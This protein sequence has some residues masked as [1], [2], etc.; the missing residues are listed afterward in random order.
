MRELGD[1]LDKDE[2]ARILRDKIIP[3]YG[4]DA[5]Q[6]HERPKA[7]ILGGQPGA[8]KGGL[9]V[10]AS[11]DLGGDAVSIDPD[12]LRTHHPKLED[13]RRENPYSWSSRTHPDASAWADELLEV[14]S[15]ERKN[16][17]F[18]ST[19]SNGE[20]AADTLIKGLKEKG[21]D[22]EIRVVAAHKMESEIGVD[23]RFAQ[24]LDERG[25]G[26]NVPKEAR[27]AIYD[28][29]PASLDVV[30]SRTDVA[31]RIFSR[32]GDELYNSQRD[33]EP[34]GRVLTEA[35]NSRLQEPAVTQ[36]LRE[37]SARLAEWNRVLPEHAKN[38]PGMDRAT[39]GRLLAEHARAHGMDESAFRAQ[40]SAIVDELVR[41]GAPPSR[42]P[43]PDLEFGGLRSSAGAAGLAGIG[44]AASAYDA[45]ET[46]ERV[47]ALLQQQ[48]LPAAQS[49]LTHFAARG[50]GGWAG[51]TLAAGIVG[52]SGAGPVAL[53]AADAYLFSK[54]FEKAA[55]L[56]DSHAI[57]QQKDKAGTEWEYNG[58][59][60]VREVALDR[61]QDGIDNPI[62]QDVSANYEK[63][64]EL[65]ALA[66]ARAV[67]LE[68]GRV[69]APQ[70]PFNIPAR[71]DDQYG[72]DNPNWRRDAQ[73]EQWVRQ[74]KTGVTGAND[75]GTYAQQIASPERAE[76]LD[77]EAMARVESNIANG[78]EAVAAAYLEGHAAL[79]SADFVEVPPAVEYARAKADSTFASD[80]HLYRLNEDGQWM[81]GGSAAQGNLAL[82]LNLTRQIRQPSLEQFNARLAETSARPA[83][84]NAEVDRSE[85]LHRYQNYNVRVPEEWVPAIELAT[86]RTREANGLTGRTLQ[87][88]Q[89]DGNSPY[90]AE[91]AV[92][93]YQAGP[94]GVAHRVAI[95]SAEDIRQAHRDL[96]ER[97]EKPTLQ[98][99]PELRIDALSADERDAYQ[100][101]LREANRQGASTDEAEQL[102]ALAAMRADSIRFDEVRV[103]ELVENERDTTQPPPS[104]PA[105]HLAAAAIA[106]SVERS[107][108][109]EQST[110]QRE[111]QTAQG[112]EQGAREHVEEKRAQEAFARTAEE[113][114]ARREAS[115][116][117]P[118]AHT[119]PTSP[120][121]A[122]T[123]IQ[124]V[125]EPEPVERPPLEVPDLAAT[126]AA[127]EA[128]VEHPVTPEAVPETVILMGASQ[129]EVAVQ[130]E[131]SERP[132]MEDAASTQHPLRDEISLDEPVTE[133]APRDVV[134][135]VV[136]AEQPDAVP[137]K[138]PA[139]DVI[140]NQAV[141]EQRPEP[142]PEPE[143]E[144]AMERVAQ[145]ADEQEPWTPLNPEHPDHALYQQIREGVA[146][147]D[148]AHGRSYDQTSERL[149]GSLMVLAKSNGLDSVD[150]V[151]LSQPTADQPGGQNVFVVQGELDN[152]GHQRA[153]M[154]TA[155]A[156]KTPFEESLEQFDVAAFEQEQ[157]AAQLATQQQEEDQRVQ[158]EMQVAAASMGY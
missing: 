14:A 76:A 11:A 130:A 49:E 122:S 44:L 123:P 116:A 3:T 108:V 58:Y 6:S 63:A 43:L 19:L 67:E 150:H 144:P 71:A 56:R 35:R 52:T 109:E 148:E 74:V 136:A 34:P 5:A 66:S 112:A 141:P 88:L 84:S 25:F 77:R 47:G 28:K 80:G 118:Q 134:E 9:A 139:N 146:K 24:S 73:S 26:R 102:A 96:Q 97:Q 153:G 151:V 111:P 82:E 128:K 113:E 62:K 140:A 85:L 55:T 4:V 100:Q 31:I 133:A 149:T 94:D 155:Q 60:W 65:N 32:E 53:V 152:P 78:K 126:V 83:P 37:R 41:P 106:A 127:S 110:A 154:P 138:E 59:S 27:D 92:A 12:E 79:R 13:F 132:S 117:E 129:P 15:S 33:P 36:D 8:G 121:I 124:P 137:L 50:I 90:S 21:Y 135:Q 98:D 18:D 17:I 22:V 29:T 95:T 30:H 39:Q 54:A 48:N 42:A 114:E 101:A 72:L 68:L 69:P 147:L 105:P 70:D 40:A 10:R 104:Q 51:G 103:P 46:G 87:E 157:R 158:Q 119:A 115:V 107:A 145:P 81:H 57:Y 89:R 2:H 75:R 61:T 143:P 142:E 38:I 86:Q 1:Q 16:L 23:G 156:V 45:H 64:R 91:S 131:A 120:D 20:W 125:P 7:I 99:T 93:H